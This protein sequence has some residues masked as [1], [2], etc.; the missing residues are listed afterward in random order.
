[1]SFRSWR[2]SPTS[3]HRST[4]PRGGGVWYTRCGGRPS[5]LANR[6]RRC[7]GMVPS[8]SRRVGAPTRLEVD[9]TMPVHLRG[10]F[11]SKLGLPPHLVYQTPPPLGFVDL[12]QLVGLPRQDLKDIPFLP[13]VPPALQNDKNIF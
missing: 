13:Y 9:G 1:M 3:C 8:T 5:L 12:W 4:N 2:G 10:L 6:P 7:T 11:A